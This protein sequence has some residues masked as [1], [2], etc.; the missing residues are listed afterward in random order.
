MTELDLKISKKSKKEKKEKKEKKRSKSSELEPSVNT[1]ER[2]EP[3]TKKCKKEKKSKKLS[4]EISDTKQDITKQDTD[5][6]IPSHSPITGRPFSSNAMEILRNQ[7][8]KLPCWR[9]KQRFL[10]LVANNQVTVLVGE[11]G[12]GKTTQCPQFLAEVYT[13]GKSKKKIGICQPRRVAAMSVATRVAEEMDVELGEECG[14]LIRF[15]DKTSD[16]TC[17]KYMTDGMLLRECMSDPELNDYSV[18][19]L[20]EAH[21]RT[22]STDILF[23]LLK[24]LLYSKEST[25]SF[26]GKNPLRVVIMS[27][28][29]ESEKFQNFFTG[30]PLITI[31]G[32]MFPV[33]LFH[34]Q[35]AERDYVNAA[36][37]T[38][39]NICYK[40][41]NY[42]DAKQG[43]N[44]IGM[45]SGTSS[46]SSTSTSIVTP[47]PD[48]S[49]DG[50]I[51][52]FLNGEEE[53]EACC[54]SLEETLNSESDDTVVLP[55]YSAL[56]PQQQRLVFNKFP[57]T[58]SRN[59]NGKNN[60]QID[61]KRKIVVAT[62]VA[63]TAVTIDGVVYVIDCGLVK[64][65][66]YN[67]RTQVES[68]LVT[69]ISK[70]AAKQRSGRAGRTRPGQT[71][72]LYTENAFHTS[73]LTNS[74]PEIL[75]TNLASAVL[76][77]FKLGIQDV[78]HFDWIDPPAP[79]SMMRAL[80]LLLLLGA[81]DEENCL[82]TEN[83]GMKLAEMPLE[84]CLGK[85]LITGSKLGVGEQMAAIVALL[86]GAPCMMRPR[87]FQKQADRA[88]RQF[89]ST[90]GDHMT[91]LNIFNGYLEVRDGR[92]IGGGKGTYVKN[93]SDSNIP[94]VTSVDKT[95]NLNA[96]KQWAYDNYL[97]DR[98][99]ESAI[100]VHKQLL[101]L[102]NK[103]NIDPT[104]TTTNNNE[105]I[106]VRKALIGGFF[107]NGAHILP[108][109]KDTYQ[110]V[111]DKQVV[112]IHP[113]SVLGDYRPE[114]VIFH[115][116]CLTDKSYIR[117]CSAVRGEW[118]LEEAGDFYPESVENEEARRNLE[119]K[120][121]MMMKL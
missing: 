16:R 3:P 15:E 18:I 28:T 7:R 9:E 22:L 66:T 39:L 72:R 11:T 68:L 49:I 94:S 120:K 102:M 106:A 42:M 25:R 100:S 96:A 82:L 61:Y 75:R 62:N 111:R 103:L 17:V 83:V 90:D 92:R 55:L 116:L 41:N 4:D 29:L 35:T 118:L 14:Y 48:T 77:L 109:K 87:K 81:V 8:C 13:G 85:L 56:P 76:T 59:D 69:P 67:P 43:G 99:L 88:H 54:K 113:G 89:N 98:S 80:E 73:L 95:G 12:S 105:R 1:V 97:K 60:N 36:V 65:K 93:S 10:D 24:R 33:D 91:L 46:S 74:V 84:P 51:L 34:T 78:V 21:E 104:T 101:R 64:Q 5:E 47:I 30:A 19:C 45:S 58:K 114:W 31:S 79:E 71:Y 37:E 110:T 2:T 6:S 38:A 86:S 115:E 70:A 107:L 52:I 112:E 117:T 32:R 20:D 119:R 121:K 40:R 26:Q 27:A 53:I 57:K 108:G 63:E 23:G 44:F 50:D